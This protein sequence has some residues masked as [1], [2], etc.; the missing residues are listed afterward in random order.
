VT[1]NR[2]V[3]RLALLAVLSA[4]VVGC[5]SETKATGDGKSPGGA[6]AATPTPPPKNT[7]QPRPM[8]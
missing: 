7:K 8:D 5:G 1:L 6:G 2:L 3:V 4:C